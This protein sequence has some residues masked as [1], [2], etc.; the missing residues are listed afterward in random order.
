MRAN[1]GVLV[2]LAVLFGANSALAQTKPGAKVYVVLWFDTEDYL[3]PASDDAAMQ[4]A[5]MLTRQG[6]R[7]TFKI[8]GEKART[9]ERRKRFDVIEALKK[10]EI[11]YHSNWHSV[12]PTPALFSS[13]LDW[14]EGV[15]E[16]DRR[17]GSGWRDVERIFGVKPSCYG[18]PGS[19]WSPHSYGALKKWGMI[20]LDAGR[21]VALDG[22]PC[23][24]AGVLN[25][26]QL[27]HTIRADLNKPELL[28][29]ANE[30]FAEAR[31]DLLAQGGGI[32][33]T[34]YHPCEWV[35]LEFWD[36]VN[37]KQ[38]ANPPR[39]QW[40][41]PRQKSAEQSRLSYRI[42]AD[43]IAFMKRFPDV[44][45]VT[46]SELA[47][48]YA[49]RAIGRRFSRA[50]LKQIA[51]QVG[52]A[53]TFQKHGDWTLSASEVFDLL[54]RV[55]LLHTAGKK[56]EGIELTRTLLGP[57]S[58]VVPLREAVTTD[59]SQ[60]LRTAADVDDY[61]NRHGRLPAA[62]WL[63]STPVPPE[64]Y[65]AALA[66]VVGELLNGKPMPE[67]VTISPAKLEAAKYV[68]QDD[69]RL[70]GWVIFPPGFRA[71]QMMELAR[72]QAWTLKPAVLS[73]SGR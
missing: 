58:Q 40:K 63:G 23:Y 33:S 29:K 6:I 53:I 64:A 5:E 17:E 16:F 49:D 60:F 72:R 38:G 21:H 65:L 43:Y 57:T 31:K 18:Q 39:E 30:R 50:E 26:Y 44:E 71:P 13:N 66:R 1:I 15:A 14:D 67:T 3:L 34:V 59:Q 12:Q 54:N 37:F 8:V 22:Q 28:E 25:L 56:L 61:L 24:Y 19:S 2:V 36:G 7:G 48:L 4:V 55:L 51:L 46:A 68:A 45:F 52:E 69:P 10:H 11:G 70:W 41:L 20:Y 9:L 35:H 62:V 32:V 73:N 47:K 27:A 42:F